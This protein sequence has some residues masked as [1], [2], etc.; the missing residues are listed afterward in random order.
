MSETTNATKITHKYLLEPVLNS[1]L[2]LVNN[3]KLLKK[4]P[5]L[6][7]EE[8]LSR[9]EN[10]RN[11][12]ITIDERSESGEMGLQKEKRKVRDEI[13][14]LSYITF[15]NRDTNLFGQMITTMSKK[16]VSR[17]QFSNYTIKDEMQSLAIQHI[18]LYTWKFNPYIQS[19]I[20][21]Q[22]ASAF[23]YI[24]TIIFNAC[25]ASIN[26]MHKDQD[27][28]KEDFLE[29]QKL[30]HRD[31]NCSTYEEE[32]THSE[33]VRTI[34]FVELNPEELLSKIKSITIREETEFWIPWDYKITPRDHDYILKY[35]Y[36]ISIRRIKE[37]KLQK[38]TIDSN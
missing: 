18:L 10:L 37:T 22:Y 32:I 28:A 26:K 6:L 2:I 30:I 35:E 38:E 23:A 7:N 24:S 8:H 29:H 15:T 5:D 17:P 31:P 20:T 3:A 16:I 9:I 27:K 19:K 13:R 21:G 11:Q 14:D 12:F 33:P 36:N 1:E 4:N 34:N 25:V